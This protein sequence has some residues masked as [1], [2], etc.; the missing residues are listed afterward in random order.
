MLNA[1]SGA[2]PTD[3]ALNSREMQ[4]MLAGS[5]L[6]GLEVSNTDCVHAFLPIVSQYPSPIVASSSHN[7]PVFQIDCLLREASPDDAVENSSFRVF[8]LPLMINRATN[9]WTV[10]F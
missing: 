6:F 10:R 9:A 3:S 5:R 2:V 8:W 7:R 1:K 4:S